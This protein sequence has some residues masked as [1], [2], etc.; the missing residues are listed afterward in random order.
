MFFDHLTLA[1]ITVVSFYV[2]LPVLFRK[3]FL[4]VDAEHESGEVPIASSLPN[5]TLPQQELSNSYSDC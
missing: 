1:G 2:L 3:E 4:W 5:E